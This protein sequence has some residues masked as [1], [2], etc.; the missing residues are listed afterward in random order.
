MGVGGPRSAGRWA[1][2]TIRFFFAQYIIDNHESTSPSLQQRKSIVMMHQFVVLEPASR[3]AHRRADRHAAARSPPR[4]L[5]CCRN[6][7]VF[8]F[9]PED[10]PAPAMFRPRG[11]FSGKL[12]GPRA[13][14]SKSPRCGR[15]GPSHSSNPRPWV[16]EVRKKENRRWAPWRGSPLIHCE[17]PCPVL[18]RADLDGR[19]PVG[20]Q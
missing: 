16:L 12:E 14:I 18:G 20:L 10:F 1:H 2:C 7:R 3:P 17:L 19:A 4:V 11:A 8:F 9:L 6:P 15:A 5:G 13:L